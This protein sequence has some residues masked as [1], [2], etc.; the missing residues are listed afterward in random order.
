M[1]DA[2][3]I[4]KLFYDTITHVNKADYTPAQI[5]AW[6]T[7]SQ[8]TEAWRNKIKEQYFFVAELESE[9]VGFSSITPE[10]YLD[11]MFVHKDHQREGIGTQLL[12]ALEQIA[13]DLNISEI[14]AKVSITARP[15]FKSKG[16]VIS[17]TYTTEIRGVEF[18]E[19]E[20]RKGCTAVR[21]DPSS[22]I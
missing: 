1:D 18:D 12:Q 9:I 4:S 8:N 6:R 11:Y 15:F 20:M 5:E 21:M 7:G 3:Q 13:A 16:F 2:D 10:G 19:I 17:K 14:W 22:G